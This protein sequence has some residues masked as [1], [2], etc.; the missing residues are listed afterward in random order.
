MPHDA[1]F[2]PDLMLPGLNLE[3][4]TLDISTDAET[5]SSSSL[6]WSQSR[7][8]SRS[9]HLSDEKLRLNISASEMIPGDADGCFIFASD[10]SSTANKVAQS[11]FPSIFA[12]EG[13]LLLQPDFEFDGEGNIIELAVKQNVQTKATAIDRRSE[14]AITNRVR[15]H[16]EE[17][18]QAGIN[19]VSPV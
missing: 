9:S 6:L 1:T 12:E 18:F 3:L 4:S 7:Q 19:Q 11:E 14:P 13:G 5:P 10:I 17:G 15:E 16:I 2:V 8:S